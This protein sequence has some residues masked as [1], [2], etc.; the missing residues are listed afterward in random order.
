M[1]TH[2]SE[3]SPQ[4]RQNTRPALC[5][6]SWAEKQRAPLR[7][8]SLCLRGP[9][10]KVRKAS[11]SKDT[12]QMQ[13]ELSQSWEDRRN[14]RE[15]VFVDRGWWSMQVEQWNPICWEL[16]EL[17]FQTDDVF[18]GRGPMKVGRGASLRWRIHNSG[19]GNGEMDTGQRQGQSKLPRKKKLWHLEAK[20]TL[21]SI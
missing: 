15:K 16:W 1:K 14:K 9:S 10:K 19:N 13:C 4:K 6:E 12:Y 5:E 7:D 8:H 18:P 11:Y 20:G 3:K 17:H 2:S 21:D